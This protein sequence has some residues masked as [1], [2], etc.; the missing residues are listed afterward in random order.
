MILV[1]GGTGNLGARLVQLLVEQGQTVRVLTRE[2]RRA[3]KLPK[4]VEIVAGDVRT[5]ED[6]ARAVR[7]C[8]TVISAVHGFLGPGSPSPESIDRDANRLLIRAASDAGVKHFLLVSVEGAAPQHPMSLH[9]AKYAAEQELRGSGLRF[10]I[11]R[12]TA[13]LE[14]WLMVIGGE[15]AGKGHALVF[16]AGR[17]PINFV[18]V[19]DV[20]ALVAQCIRDGA[21]NELIEIGGPENLDFVTV[22][23][24]LIEASG[25][26]GRIKHI[27]L[28]VLRVMSVLARPFSPMFARQAT[29]AV[30]MNTTDM[31]F[32]A[33]VR[34]RVPVLPATTLRDLLDRA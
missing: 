34:G 15:L 12:P 6:V 21:S 26:P 16:G 3:D 11:I 29:A 1:A 2:P 20:A 18:S 28:P 8:E 19:R 23:E 24:R 33:S 4:S 7:G 9:R 5:P 14:T 13:F 32:D 30:V 25:K 31:T 10:T 17:N 22:A 27:P